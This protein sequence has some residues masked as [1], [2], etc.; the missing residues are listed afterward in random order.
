MGSSTMTLVRK[1]LGGDLCYGT[2]D[3]ARVICTAKHVGVKA[4]ASWSPAPGYSA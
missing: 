4:L 2:F 1:R 3:V